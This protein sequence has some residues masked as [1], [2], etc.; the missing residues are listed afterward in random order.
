MANF[1]QSSLFQM[2]LA[3]R[4]KMV[5]VGRLYRFCL[6]AVFRFLSPDVDAGEKR[7]HFRRS[8][9]EPQR[10]CGNVQREPPLSRTR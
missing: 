2:K 4:E 9:S 8:R 10:H 3:T 7:S 6:Q 1:S 5:R